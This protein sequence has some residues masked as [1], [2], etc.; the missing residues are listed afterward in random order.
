MS[1]YLLNLSGNPFARKMIKQLKL[2]VPLPQNLSR[3]KRA[4]EETPLK[5]RKFAMGSASESAFESEIEGILKDAGATPAA[6]ETR[7][8]ALIF[9]GTGLKT[10]KDLTQLYD[11]FHSHVRNVKACCHMV[12]VG[13]NGDT[14]SDPVA[15]ATHKGL[16][17][18]IKSLAKET[19][20]KGITA[21]LIQLES[22]TVPVANLIGPLV[23][24]LSHRSAFISGQSLSVGEGQPHSNG[25]AG[26]LSGQY[27]IV[28][29][30]AQGI[31]KA[32]AKCLAAEGARVIGID[33]PGAKD[34]LKSAMQEIDGKAWSFDLMKE[35]SC[36][37]IVDKLNAENIKPSILVNNAGITR[38]K[39]IARMDNK[40]WS[41]TIQ[42]NLNQVMNLSEALLKDCFADDGRII[43]ISSIGGIAGNMG[44]TNYATSKSGVIG[45]TRARSATLKKQ[46]MNAIAPGFIET[47]M[48]AAMPVAVREVARRFNALS[49]A[50]AP[51]DIG[52]AVTFMAMPQS[53][54]VSGQTLRVCGLNLIGA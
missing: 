52:D 3:S 40:K 5:G 9:D 20:K 31:G 18:F 22:G 39:T 45:Y 54:G 6:G 32:I 17:G 44:Q 36:K 16:L 11:F 49:Q 50:G 10:P 43:N 48:T 2:P 13:F 37:A 30:A 24:F 23:Y 28:T 4:W 35:E 34:K 47:R 53:F 25:W 12:V 14:L 21:N 38:D 7:A 15:A 29:G 41:E 51:K 33:H 46:R 42:L 26:S 27:A 19:G 1:D 8:D